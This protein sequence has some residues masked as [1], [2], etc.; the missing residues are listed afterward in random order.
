MFVFTICY[1]IAV[2]CAAGLVQSTFTDEELQEQF[3]AKID[4]CSAF[5]LEHGYTPPAKDDPSAL[6]LFIMAYHAVNEHNSNPARKYNQVV[7][8]FATVEDMH[9]SLIMSPP[10]NNKTAGLPPLI[11]VGS[12]VGSSP[13]S[14]DRRDDNTSTSAKDQ[15]RCGSCWAFS[16]IAAVESKYLDLTGDDPAIADFSEQQFLDCTY[17]AEGGRDGCK[18]GWTTDPWTRLTNEENSILYNETQRPY[19]KSDGV[20][21]ILEQNQPNAM[22]KVVMK[23]SAY[24][25]SSDYDVVPVMGA[26]TQDR[27]WLHGAL[28]VAIRAERAFRRYDGGVFDTECSRTILN[29]A[30]TL[31]GYTQT[32]FTAKNSWGQHWGEAGHI[33]MSRTDGNICRYLTHVMWPEMECRWG[34]DASTGNCIR[35]LCKG[36]SCLNGGTC[37]TMGLCECSEEWMGDSCEVK[38]PTQAPTQGTTPAPTQAPTQGTTPAPTQVPTQGTTQEPNDYNCCNRTHLPNGI[39][40]LNGASC[41][42]TTGVCDCS[43]GW[44]GPYCTMGSVGRVRLV[45]LVLIVCIAAVIIF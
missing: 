16:G 36:I 41:N 5:Y 38:A 13:D 21:N 33:R 20:C 26:T 31:V 39:I 44:E 7:N 42:I 6:Q 37:N 11:M 4:I 3:V 24:G 17:E 23:S 12:N 14:Y 1:F 34:T 10:T 15:K 29:H 40:C 27:L 30:I 28:S 45:K 25:W 32:Y 18:G 22:S 35:E 8:C 2:L 9:N 19:N 43:D